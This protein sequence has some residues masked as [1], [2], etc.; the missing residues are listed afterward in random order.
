MPYAK[1]SMYR[2]R[3][4]LFSAFPQAQAVGFVL[5]AYD[6]MMCCTFK[7]LS[8]LFLRGKYLKMKG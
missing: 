5:L 7:F 1:G 3:C 6:Y 8:N 2:N 4:E